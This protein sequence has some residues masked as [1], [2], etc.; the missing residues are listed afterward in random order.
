MS[1]QDLEIA[2]AEF[3]MKTE[4]VMTEL[5]SI[6]SELREAGDPTSTKAAETLD[7]VKV[8]YAE[9]VGPYESMINEKI[10]NSQDTTDAALGI[11][12]IVAAIFGFGG[13]A[14]VITNRIRVN[15]E[16]SK[17]VTTMK[18]GDITADAMTLAYLPPDIATAIQ[19]V[20][21]ANAN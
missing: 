17:I 12:D 15:R 9:N 3:Q 8:W 2:K 13:I 11:V 1:T 18:K 21:S 6:T 5:D 4:A 20:K 14:G 19:K 7:A 10:L 16:R